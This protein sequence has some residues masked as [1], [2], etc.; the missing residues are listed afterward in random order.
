MIELKVLLSSRELLRSRPIIQHG[1]IRSLYV[2]ARWCHRY[3]LDAKR[4]D[5]RGRKASIYYLSVAA[6]GCAARSCQRGAHSYGNDPTSAAHLTKKSV[7][8]A[9]GRYIGSAGT[10]VPHLKTRD[11]CWTCDIYSRYDYCCARM[12]LIGPLK[13]KKSQ[14]KP[15]RGIYI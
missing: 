6:R 2:L 10:T 7:C 1:E 9:G 5:R 12:D 14:N 3:I 4:N 13:L 15:K 11:C 8:F